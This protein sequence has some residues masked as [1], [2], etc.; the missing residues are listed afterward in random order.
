MDLILENLENLSALGL[1]WDGIGVFILGVPAIFKVRTEI[2]EEAGTYW[3]YNPHELRNK[4]SGRMDISIGS[5]FLLLGF[6]FQ[7]LSSVS[8]SMPLEFCVFF[9]FSA[10]GL[11]LFYYLRGRRSLVK[12]WTDELEAKLK[13][14][15]GKA[16]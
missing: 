2:A 14:I 10:P 3:G 12:L 1:L 16:S 9:W 15:N 11:M 4:I 7:F 13:S 6:L 5:I 8:V